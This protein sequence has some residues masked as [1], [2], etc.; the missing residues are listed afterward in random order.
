M[1]T[2]Y[3]TRGTAIDTLEGYMIV[4]HRNEGGLIY[5]D[6]YFGYDDENGAYNYT[7]QFAYTASEIADMMRENDGITRKVFWKTCRYEVGYAGHTN[8]WSED[9]DDLIEYASYIRDAR[10]G[11]SGFKFTVWDNEI[12]DFVFW[13]TALATKPETDLLD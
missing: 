1:T 13:K 8:A 3:I 7:G 11:K 6:T 4:K 9:T 5:C 12:R 10:A 2:V